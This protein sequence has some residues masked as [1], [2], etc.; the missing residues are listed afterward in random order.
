MHVKVYQVVAPRHCAVTIIVPIS[1]SWFLH[2]FFKEFRNITIPFAGAAYIFFVDGDA[3]LLEQV[4]REVHYLRMAYNCRG[5]TILHNREYTEIGETHG[6][7]KRRQRIANIHNTIGGH[8]KS[9]YVFGLEDDTTVPRETLVR[10]YKHLLE[11]RRVGFAS[12]CEMGRWGIEH[13]GGWNFE[14]DEKRDVVGI[15]SLKLQNGGIVEM[16]GGGLYA[17]MAEA[18]LYWQHDFSMWEQHD[19]L[20]PDMLFGKSIRD[21][22]KKC[23]M[24]FDLWCNHHFRRNDKEDV[25]TPSLAKAVQIRYRRKDNWFPN[26]LS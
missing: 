17:F 1:R 15:E 18:K 19:F 6:Y 11:D 8:V 26:V 13:V 14:Y 10:L 21:K 22:G 16:D 23:I 4:Q 5:V 24:D 25:V 3:T 12:A 7:V 2:Q 9:E 20:G